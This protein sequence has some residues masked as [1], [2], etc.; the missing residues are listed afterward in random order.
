MLSK[1]GCFTCFLCWFFR[2]DDLFVA[3]RARNK[4]LGCSGSFWEFSIIPRWCES[5]PSL[6]LTASSHLKM[7]GWNTFI[8]SFWGVWAYFQGRLLLVF[9]ESKFK[10]QGFHW[11]PEKFPFHGCTRIDLHPRCTGIA[12]PGCYLLKKTSVK[13]LSG[14]TEQYNLMI[15]EKAWWKRR[16]VTHEIH[17]FWWILMVFC[18]FV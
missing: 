15:K 16:D 6:K 9:R 13:L 11:D 12:F 3:T 1:I 17:G 14:S 8:V 5:L 7:D 10:K 4:N 18:V 2:K